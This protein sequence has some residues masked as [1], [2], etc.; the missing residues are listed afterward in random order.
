MPL[1][2]SPTGIPGLDELIEGGFPIPSTILVAGEP[3][4]GKTTLG[5]QSLFHAAREGGVGIY[6]AAL[7]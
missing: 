5:V 1:T 4:T 7:A 6:L 2:R 3:G